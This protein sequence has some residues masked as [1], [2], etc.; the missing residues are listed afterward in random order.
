L[1]SRTSHPVNL[2]FIESNFGLPIVAP[3]GLIYADAQAKKLDPALFSL[4]TPR[5]FQA[6]PNIT[7]DSAFFTNNVTPDEDPDDD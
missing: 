1:L 6:I 4:Q 3:Q 7:Y 5:T 2:R